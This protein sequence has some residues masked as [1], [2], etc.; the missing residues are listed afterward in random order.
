MFWLKSVAQ[1]YPEYLEC[2]VPST[3]FRP[4]AVGF[5]IWKAKGSHFIGQEKHLD[6]LLRT[7]QLDAHEQ[8]MEIKLK[9]DSYKKQDQI[10]NQGQINF[11]PALEPVGI[12][13]LNN[14]N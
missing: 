9:T 12:P 11:F 8:S 7:S 14:F 3:L 6:W 5:N 4:Y 2:L 1:V 10:N 13:H